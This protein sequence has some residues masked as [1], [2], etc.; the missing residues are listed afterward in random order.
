MNL[1]HISFM[2]KVEIRVDHRLI[3]NQRTVSKV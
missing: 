1:I 2:G 3:I